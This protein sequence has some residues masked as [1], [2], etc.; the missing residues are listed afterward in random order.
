[1]SLVLYAFWCRKSTEVTACFHVGDPTAR[2]QVP[3]LALREGG[4]QA[5][6]H[7]AQLDQFRNESENEAQAAPFCTLSIVI[8]NTCLEMY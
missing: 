5:L 4:V 2:D 6:T 7:G 3:F 1:M 8:R